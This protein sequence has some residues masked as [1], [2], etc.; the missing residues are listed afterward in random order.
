MGCSSVYIADM[1]TNMSRRMT[2]RSASRAASCLA[3]SCVLA[4]CGANSGPGGAAD[5]RGAGPLGGPDPQVGSD[6]RLAFTHRIADRETWQRLA[7]RPEN[8]TVAGTEVVK[9]LI[10]LAHDEQIWFTDT[11][12]WDIH[13]RFARDVLSSAEHP[14]APG[15]EGHERFN[16]EQYRRPDRRFVLGSLVRYL[17]SDLWTMEMVAGDT[18]EGERVLRAFERVRGAVYFGEQLRYRPISELHEH[19]IAAVAGRLPTVTSDEVFAGVRYQ[20]L[21]LGVA[22][23]TLRFVR[24]PLD[25]STV[26]PDQILVLEQ[27]PDEIPVVG[28]VISRQMQA[29]LGHLALLCATRGTPNMGLR[30]ALTDARLTSLEG[31]LVRLSVDPQEPTITLAT[32]EETERAWASRRPESPLTP[33]I[34][35]TDRGLPELCSLN[36]GDA[37]SVGAK[38]AQLGEACRMGGVIRTPGGFAVPF[39]AYLRHVAR[40]GAARGI[41]GMLADEAFQ[42][43]ARVR[44][45]RLAELR[46][47]IEQTEVDPRFLRA[48]RAR[49]Q[50]FAGHPRVILRSSTNAEDLPGFTGAGLYRSVVVNGNASERE[51][52][53]ALR[54]V[55]ASVWL[56]GAYDEREWYRIDHARVAMGVLVQPFVDG[57]MVNGVA[58]TR[59][60]FYAGRPG[61]F[62][63]AQG[64][65]G[66]VTAAAG[67]ELPEQHVIYTYSEEIESEILSRSS[68]DG[69]ATLLGERDIAR[70]A[71]VLVA[72]HEHFEPFW[73]DRANAV[74]VEFL[75]AGPDRDVIVLQARPFQVVYQ[76]G[77]R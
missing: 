75:I 31:Q 26:T 77:Q 32:R 16:I 46:S 5:P 33:T 13:Y 15:Y 44:E 65:S 71:E 59:N 69:G 45:T 19:R 60:P 8:H 68:R 22:Y 24:G 50:A 14:V 18:L 53:D 63:N 1:L 20:P 7:A 73:T 37:D 42:Q 27:L 30:D 38:A 23:G 40:S 56:R 74:D 39:H 34:D 49:I 57:A 47:I 4:S 2:S 21:T 64:L 51:I 17:D 72:L 9:F 43:D 61:L 66:S 12:R 58:I 48:L 70:L 25:L 41:S 6:G 35:A 3:L 54:E 11:E 76:D 52:A 36:I 67:D 62:V 10:D 55:W 29:P 28:G